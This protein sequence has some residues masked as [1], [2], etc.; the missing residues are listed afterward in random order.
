MAP[1]LALSNPLC[2][3]NERNG[4]DFLNSFFLIQMKKLRSVLSGHSRSNVAVIGLGYVG[5]PLCQFFVSAGLS[6]SG[7]DIDQAKVA[8]L[9]SGE[10]PISD[11]SDADVRSLLRNGLEVF[12]DY[13]P[14]AKAD[15]ILIALPTPIGDDREPDLT[16]VYAGIDGVAKNLAEASLIVVESTVAP[17]TT[18][19]LLLPR[20][21]STGK[22][23]GKDFFLA[24]SP[25]RVDPGGQNGHLQD[26]PKIVAGADPNSHA[27]AVEFYESA[28][29][30]V[31]EAQSVAEAEAA[32]LLENTYRAVN[33]AL[34]NELAPSLSSMGIDVSEVVRLAGTKPFGFQPF[35][36]GAGVGGHC[37][38]IDPWYLEFAIKEAGGQSRITQ[39]ALLVNDNMPREVAK[40]IAELLES[41]PD[42]RTGQRDVLLLGMTYKPNVG[43][44]RESPGRKVALALHDLGIEVSYHDPFL[45][46][47]M[48][49]LNGLPMSND[50]VK[51]MSAHRATVVLQ[52][53]HHYEPL[54]LSGRPGLWWAMANQP[55][56]HPSLWASDIS[57]DTVTQ[58]ATA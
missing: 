2:S 19:R 44:F 12:S 4:K 3:D 32:K 25:E 42:S 54:H 9:R 1:L 40:R 27:R 43:D 51:D 17:G 6:V 24:F 13:S 49:E 16:A 14:V 38:P 57:L 50:Y 52:D 34:V 5:L 15:V 45:E 39:M 20:I 26:I 7:I 35:F 11:L 22:E 10:S 47:P 41:V 56:S 31:V 29:F 48:P 23:L 58:K 28:G 30:P 18:T 21:E 33:M 46:A 8:K 36:P 37:I 55:S 53:H